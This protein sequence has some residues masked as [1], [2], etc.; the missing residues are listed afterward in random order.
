MHLLKHLILFLLL[1]PVMSWATEGSDDAYAFDD[2]MLEEELVYPD[3]FKLSFGDLREDL[4]EALE[5]GKKG[6]VLYFGQKRCSYC[7][8]F[9]EKDLGQPDIASY[10]RR[11][12]DV[13]PIDIWDID[14]IIDTDG[15]EHSEREL[16]LK[17]DTNFTPSLVFY[18]ENGKPVFRLRGFYPPY[19]FRA[20]LKYVAE[21]FYETESFRDYLARAE[22]GMFFYAEGLNERDFFMD[23]PQSLDRTQTPGDKPLVVFFEK[24]DCHACDLLHSGPL[25]D[26]RVIAEIGKMDAVQLNM[27]SEQQIT[28]PGGE[29]MEVVEWADKL[30]LFHAPTLIFFDEN[31]KEV[32]RVDSVVQ[33]YRLWGVLDYINEKGYEESDYQKWRL[34]KREISQAD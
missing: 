20:A 23:V 1:T 14:D 6:I 8:Q 32:M 19:K 15:S 16:A 5:A 33:F 29:T 13:I 12:F 7:E 25:N 21:K 9:L 26:E 3:W 2:T 4:R 18:D 34:G 27:S 17:Y 31:G 30:G 24:G 10:M 22:P 28:T 11:N